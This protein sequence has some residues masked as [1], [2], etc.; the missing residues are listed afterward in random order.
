MGHKPVNKMPVSERAKQFAPFAAVRGLAKA[1]RQKELEILSMSKPELSEEATAAINRELQ[2]LH[3][4]K[5]IKAEYF[6]NGRIL[7][8]SGPAEICGGF[9][10]VNGIKIPFTAL[11]SV[12]SI[13]N[14]G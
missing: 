3:P 1:L 11:L 6:F 5:R 14:E 8:V 2:E 10:T 13:G 9:L 4:G 7:T 12:K